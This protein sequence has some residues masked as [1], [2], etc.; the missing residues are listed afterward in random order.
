MLAPQLAL[1]GGPSFVKEMIKGLD[2]PPWVDCLDQ[3]GAVMALI[4]VRV[5]RL[6]FTGPAAVRLKLEDMGA[7][8]GV[9][10]AQALEQPILELAFD[11]LAD[12]VLRV[13]L[14][15]AGWGA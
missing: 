10:V 14:D 2:P 8:V 15:A 12:R 1:M 13:R 4:R 9:R 11:E 3:R 6:L 7:G 5:P